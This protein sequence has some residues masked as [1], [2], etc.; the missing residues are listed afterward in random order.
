MENLN[1]FHGSL[2]IPIDC[3]SLLAEISINGI[4][5][6][7]FQ[8]PGMLTLDGRSLFSL[9]HM[10]NKVWQCSLI[11]EMNYLSSSYKR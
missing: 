8:G 9:G 11:F 5:E 2:P 3:C 4:Q 6:M 7:Q 10:E 1:S